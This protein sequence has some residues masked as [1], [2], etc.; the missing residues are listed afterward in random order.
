VGESSD[1]ERRIWI[2]EN[3][4][5]SAWT[6]KYA[7]VKSIVPK[8]NTKDNF[9]ELIQTLK[10]IKEYGIE[11]VRGSIFTS[12][13]PLSQ[14]EK[15]MAAQLYCELH[16][17]CR[18]CGGSGHFISQC[19]KKDVEEWVHQFG[20]VLQFEKIDTKRICLGCDTEISSLPK[21]YKY[22]RTCF[23]EKNKY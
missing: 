22:C 9:N 14:Y 20:G 18:K 11:N 12:Q 5:G 2:H 1:V 10:T 8:Y 16:G 13:F 15:V 7:V 19:K 21:N 17:L 23:Y 4:N 6:K 3:G